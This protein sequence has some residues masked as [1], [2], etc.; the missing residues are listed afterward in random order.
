MITKVVIT[1]M[2]NTKEIMD[3]TISK[4]WIDFQYKAF[5]F[6]KELHSF[7]KGYLN[8]HRHRKGG[9]GKLAKA[10][11]FDADDPAGAVSWGIGNI[12]VLNKEVPYWY[13]INYG[14]KV[15]GEPF[16]PGGGKFVPGFFGNG[17]AP[18]PSMRGVGTERFTYTPGKG[19][20]SG[21]VAGII[22]PIN[23]IEMTEAKLNQGL[24]KLLNAFGDSSTGGK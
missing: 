3:T 7:M 16:I 12:D 14:R 15:S 8:A 17:V 11:T 18:D 24:Y 21:M 9:T 22:R 20:D 13:V 4:H 10:I 2:F 19:I 5:L 6:G 1:P 23:Y